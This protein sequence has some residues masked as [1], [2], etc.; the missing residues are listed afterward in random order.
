MENTSRYNAKRITLYNHKG[1]VGK[2]V[3]TANIAA[4]IAEL[5]HRVLIVDSDPQS[6]LTSYFIEDSVVDSLLDESDSESGRTLWSALKPL[7][8]GE[9]SYITHRSL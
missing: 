6:N 3:L 7:V 8:T 1:G 5:G 2:T 9:G 4:A